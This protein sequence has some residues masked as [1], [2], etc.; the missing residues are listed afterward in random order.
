MKNISAKPVVHRRAVAEGRL[1]LSQE[2]AEMILQNAVGKGDVH[3]T[4]RLAAVQAVKATPVVV[5]ECHPITITSVEIHTEL[6]DRTFLARVAVEA[7]DRTG[8]ELEALNGV[9][10]ALLNVWDLV[11]PYEKDSRGLYP[12]TR[13]RDVRVVEKTKKAPEEK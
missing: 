9:L 3:Q 1:E 5:F 4:A 6:K 2:S 10:M 12:L 11:K 7:L 13:I 8:C